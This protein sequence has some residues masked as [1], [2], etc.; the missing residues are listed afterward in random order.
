MISEFY[1]LFKIMSSFPFV[2]VNSAQRGSCM[3][4][5][6]MSTEQFS[7]RMSSFGPAGRNGRSKTSSSTPSASNNY[8]YS[9]DS[10]SDCG[11]GQIGEGY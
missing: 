9:L 6:S 5:I 4:G 2:S 11:Y 7:N 1:S 8:G 3:S 10:T